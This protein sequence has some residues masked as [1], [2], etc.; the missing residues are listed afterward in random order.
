MNLTLTSIDNYKLNAKL[1]SGATAEVYLSSE[2]EN[3]SNQKEVAVKILKKM[4]KSIQKEAEILSR[5]NHHNVLRLIKGG[6]GTFIKKGNCVGEFPYI[7]LEYAEKGELFNYVYLPKKGFG[8][9]YGRLIFKQIMEGLNACHRAG[10]AH[11]DLKLENIMLDRNY[12]VKIADFGFATFLQGKNN[13]GRLTTPLG[14]M[15]YAAPEILMRRPYDGVLSDIFSLGVV[16]FVMVTGK[17]GF[18]RAAR[19]DRFYNCIMHK[20]I[21]HYWHL[22][23]KTGMTNQLSNE[24]KDLYLKMISFNPNERPTLLQIVEH[25]WINLNQSNENVNEM[26]LL[27]ELQSREII[28]RQEQE[29][30]MLMNEDLVN[31]SQSN[32]VYKGINEH[33]GCEE[34]FNKKLKCI[35]FSNCLLQRK[36]MT[37]FKIKGK[38]NP[39]LFMNKIALVIDEKT[40]G[41]KVI[42]PS[43]KCLKMKIIYENEEIEPEENEIVDENEYEL[44]PIEKE[45]LC[46]EIKM[47]CVKDNEEYILAFY[48][49]SGDRFEYCDKIEEIK[50]L[51]N[52]S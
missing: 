11:R 52:E 5:I 26:S 51:I 9:D 41:T 28:I 27:M 16:L 23:A 12:N 29:L 30:Q 10:I 19:D 6:Q 46:I 44:E 43:N 2:T 39:V 25:P 47:I 21:E 1:G 48:K 13:D 33:S 4:D 45:Q 7:V 40:K 49:K 42:E 20:K 38:V 24:F 22:L 3:N 8:E 31:N 14:T 36:N 34:Y 32:A 17:M 15:A 18:V 35:K 37:I 50:H